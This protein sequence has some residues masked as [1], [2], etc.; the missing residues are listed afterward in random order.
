MNEW[1]NSNGFDKILYV[2]TFYVIL[3]KRIL[4]K[5]EVNHEF[6]F[7][8]GGFEFVPY[9]L[10]RK[11]SLKQLTDNAELVVTIRDSYLKTC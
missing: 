9:V 11:E 1:K 6:L 5:A 4:G 10:G 2:M 8:C 7:G 3:E